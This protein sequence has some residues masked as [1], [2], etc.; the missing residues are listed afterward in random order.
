MLRLYAAPFIEASDAL[1]AAIEISE[2]LVREGKGS[3]LVR[4]IPDL[5]GHFSFALFRFRDPE[6][7]G[8]LPLS[9]V[10]WEEVAILTQRCGSQSVPDDADPFLSVEEARTLFAALQRHLINDLASV[11][12][13]TVDTSR[14][15]YYQQEEP[16]FGPEVARR[17]PKAN[18]DIAAASRCLALEE[19][20]A[21]VFHSMRVLE[22]GLRDMARKLR[23]PMKVKLDE[24]QW[25]QIIAA[26]QNEIKAQRYPTGKGTALTAAKRRRLDWY[27][28]MA[29]NF[30]YFNDSWRK[31]VSH[32]R[33]TY[34]LE[35]ATDVFD[36]VKLFMGGLARGPGR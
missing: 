29:T 35:E 16:P 21:C 14:Q 33:K 8:S 30:S 20:T 17:F 23:V 26:I 15:S 10:T 32:A 22:L 11:V 13:L 24:A 36:H 12:F 7:M 3:V 28:E 19:W 25:G 6:A 2:R 31:H 27:E 4:D 34:H 9:R 5:S 1:T 18:D